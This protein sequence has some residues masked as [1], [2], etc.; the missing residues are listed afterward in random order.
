LT[1]PAGLGLS[2]SKA[3][4]DAHAGT[5]AVQT[6]RGTGSTLIVELP[7]SPSAPADTQDVL[8]A[9]CGSQASRTA[10]RVAC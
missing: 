1:R 8:S 9:A 2:S 10:R 3:I 5:I 4:V 7:A 6:A